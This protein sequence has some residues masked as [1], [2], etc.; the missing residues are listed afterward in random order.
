MPAADQQIVVGGES[1]TLRYSLKAMIALQD[2]FGVKSLTAVGERLGSSE[3]LGGEDIAAVLW[4][5]L[6]THHPDTSMQDVIDALDRVG[7]DAVSEVIE[8]AFAA[9]APAS[10]PT[11]PPAE[12]SEGTTADSPS[13]N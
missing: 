10:D 1:Y 13:I 11:Q 7:L 9:A 8:K 6:R 2:H 4:A 12:K 3:E 5:G